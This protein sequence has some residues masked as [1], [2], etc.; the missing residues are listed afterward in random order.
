MHRRFLRSNATPL[1]P[2]AI[3]E[4]RN[5]SRNISNAGHII[6]KKYHIGIKRYKDIKIDWD[7]EIENIYDLYAEL[8]S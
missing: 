2:K 1:L 3:K 5:A 4:I 8:P 7:K 6:C